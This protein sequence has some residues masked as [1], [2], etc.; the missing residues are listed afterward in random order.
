MTK[1]ALMGLG[2]MLLVC[3]TVAFAAVNVKGAIINALSGFQ[4]N[5]AAPA[6]HTLCG[7]GTVYVDAASCV[8]PITGSITITA[9]SLPSNTCYTQP[10]TMSASVPS[11]SVV[12]VSVAQ[13]SAT[14]GETP[15]AVLSVSGP[16][17]TVVWCNNFVGSVTLIAGTYN[18]RASQ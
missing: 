7:N 15:P 5:G 14:T 18:L 6:N 8:T 9:Q 17:A 13:G 16:T 11:L 1:K 4:Y 2:V 12:G 3:V 10:V